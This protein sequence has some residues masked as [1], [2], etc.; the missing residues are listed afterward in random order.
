MVNY[1][2]FSQAMR[3]IFPFLSYLLDDNCPRMWH[4][5]ASHRQR[6]LANNCHAAVFCR[7]HPVGNMSRPYTDRPYLPIF[8]WLSLTL[9]IQWT[10]NNITK[11]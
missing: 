8:Q 6:R 10:L 7:I 2:Y 11:I 9:N 3:N 1:S 5:G 4:C